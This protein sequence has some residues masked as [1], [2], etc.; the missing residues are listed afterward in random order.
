MQLNNWLQAHGGVNRLTW[1]TYIA[2]GPRHKPNW[3]SEC[4]G[5]ATLFGVAIVG[6]TI[7]L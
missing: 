5:T 6:L 7:S 3:H 2:G 1:N 4:F